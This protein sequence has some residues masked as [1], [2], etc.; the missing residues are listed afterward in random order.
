[1]HDREQSIL[2]DVVVKGGTL[3]DPAQGLNERMD[4]AISRG[5]IESVKAGISGGNAKKVIDASGM[6]VTP[7]LVDLHTHTA[8]DVTKLSVD[9]ES[10][11]LLRGTTTVVDAGTTGELNFRPFKRFVID[12]SRARILA[13][14]N[15]ESLGMIEFTQDLPGNTDQGWPDLIIGLKESFA[16]LFVNQKNTMELIRRNR[17]SI[18]GIKWAH[19]G[20]KI[21]EKAREAA[22]RTGCRLMIENH[23]MPD[24][25]RYVKRGD[26]VTHLYHNYNNPRAGYVDGLTERGKIR[27]EFFEAVKR[28]VILDVGHG[29]GSF[30]WK[31][32]ELGFRE[33]I[34]PQTIS[35]DLWVGNLNGPVYDLPTTIA[36]LLYLGM[37]LEEVVRACTA[38]PASVVKRL[39]EIGTLRHGACADVTIFKLKNGKF[40]LI[41][42]TGAARMGTQIPTPIHVIRGGTVVVSNGE[43]VAPRR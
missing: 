23:H 43:P 29:R 28:G 32:A 35:T 42:V 1:V 38:T 7:G 8:Y 40:P 13:F 26:I 18:V 27:P 3:I 21:L 2:Y 5:R 41:D 39:G 34:K 9:P 20:K 30:V 22:D 19:H 25:L 14:I 37:N 17:K 10:A 4:V 6:I 12:R 15:I 36:K 31:I 24:A 11:C 16:T 33:G